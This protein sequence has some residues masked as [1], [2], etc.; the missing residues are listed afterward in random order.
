MHYKAFVTDAVAIK[1][2]NNQIVSICTSA[3]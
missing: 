3:C 2:V 1:I